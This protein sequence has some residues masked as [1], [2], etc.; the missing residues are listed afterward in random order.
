MDG[1]MQ[2]GVMEGILVKNETGS[3]G[4]TTFFAGGTDHSA[5]RVL[6]A[7][8]GNNSVIDFLSGD[9]SSPF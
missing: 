3:S 4:S 5:F 9:H 2:K 6:E 1:V 8:D 7:S